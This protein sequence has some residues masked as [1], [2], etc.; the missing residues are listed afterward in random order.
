[1]RQPQLGDRVREIVTQREGVVTGD[2]VYLWGCRQLLIHYFDV[3]G[4]SQTEWY[5]VGRLAVLE[6]GVVSAI[7]YFADEPVRPLAAHGPDVPA[8]RR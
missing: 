4:K 2:C 3:D 7:D 8:P 6:Q 5:D 1:M